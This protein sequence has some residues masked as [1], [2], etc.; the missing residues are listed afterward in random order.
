MVFVS[1]RLDEVVEI[2]ER[3]TVLRDGRKVGTFPASEVDDHRLRRADDRE[4][5]EH[6]VHA[7]RDQLED[8]R[9]CSRCAALREPASSRTSPSPCTAGEMLGLIGLLGAGR[10][11]LALA[12]FGMTRLDRG[13]DPARWG[14]RSIFA[15]TRTPSRPASPMSRRIDFRSASTSASRSPTTYRSPFSTD[16]PTRLAW[17]ASEA[18]SRLG[19]RLGGTARDQGATGGQRRRSTL[20]GGNQQRVVLAKWLATEPKVLILDSPTVGV[21]IRNKQ[22][23]Y[24]VVRQLAERGVAILLISDEV[25]EVYFNCDRVLHMRDGRI[26]GEF[27]PGAVSEHALAE[28]VYA[29]GW[30]LRSL[31]RTETALAAA[32]VIAAI[33]FSFASPY[34]L[35]AP[36]FVDLIEAYSVTTILAAGVFVVLVSGGIDISFTATASATQYLGGLSG[37]R[38]RLCRRSQP[39]ALAAA[40]GIAHGHAST[41]C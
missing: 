9:P 19:C 33:I 16:S 30:C 13:R 1:H 2:A 37:H 41:R 12:L 3:V 22:G 11:E 6:N 38:L 17:I 7:R 23:I 32:I 39:L 29:L 35:T 25:P 26:V 36:N 34:F 5:I 8:R 31:G 18:R 4:I 15:P 28:A 21:D 40:L 20:S 14:R 10:T 27:V 24:D